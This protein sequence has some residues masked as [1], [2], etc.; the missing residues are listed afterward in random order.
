MCKRGRA[1]ANTTCEAKQTQRG[2]CTDMT[3][4]SQLAGLVHYV[5]PP[6]PPPPPLRA[7]LRARLL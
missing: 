1:D 2:Y 4:R 7:P 3:R 6:P 5:A